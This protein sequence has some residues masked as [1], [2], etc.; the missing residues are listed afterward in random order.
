MQP[1]AHPSENGAGLSRMVGWSAGLHLMVLT[2]IVVM[3]LIRP[4]PTIFRDVIRVDLVAP[5]PPVAEPK[6]E[7]KPVPEPPPKP[8]LP[9]LKENP[10]WRNLDR[11]DAPK[12]PK[13]DKPALAEM[14][15]DYSKEPPKPKP[16]PKQEDLTKWWDAEMRQARRN[17][18]PDTP[19]PVKIPERERLA[20]AWKQINATLP[21]AVRIGEAETQEQSQGELA[22][23]WKRQMDS[24]MAVAPERTR[25][26]SAATE[27]GTP[28][29]R[30]M[31]QQRVAVR[32]SPPDIFRDRKAVSVVLAFEL[33]P[34]GHVRSVK[35]RE[36]SGSSFYDQAA[37]RAIFL[38]DPFPPFPEEVKEPFLE[39]HMTFSLDRGRLG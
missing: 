21:E 19:E 14:W 35:V 7:P 5:T 9:P 33:M 24:V 13:S 25:M 39:I 8:E 30:A 27:L 11:I 12:P 16:P 4:R 34:D 38:A 3:D 28:Q 20:D 31:V 15:Q 2:V 37:L 23:W 22:N 10:L 36:S 18:A 1:I 29:Y 6:P 26:A 17:P 32:W